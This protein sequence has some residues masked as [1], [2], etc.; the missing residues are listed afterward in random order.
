MVKVFL[1]SDVAF[2]LISYRDPFYKEALPLLEMVREG[3]I[4]LVVSESSLGNLFYLSFERYKLVDAGERLTDLI[5][6]CEIISA[7]KEAFTK[8]LK[9]KFKDKEDALQYYTASAHKADLILTRNKKDFLNEDVKIPI[10]T[11]LEFF[12]C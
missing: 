12:G 1:D 5:A 10:F 2:D 9:S 8:A 11:P 6:L 3:S 7:G 4:L